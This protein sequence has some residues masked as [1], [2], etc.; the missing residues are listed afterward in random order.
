MVPGCAQ[1]RPRCNGH[2]ILQLILGHLEQVH[3]APAQMTLDGAAEVAQVHIRPRAPFG[4]P[5]E[6]VVPAGDLGAGEVL[7]VPLAGAF[8]REHGLVLAEPAISGFVLATASGP[9]WA[10][11]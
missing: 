9:D 4:A 1:A 10:H 6:V 3:R 11:F 8:V 5:E 2:G 7:R